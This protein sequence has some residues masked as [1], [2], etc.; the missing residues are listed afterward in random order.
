MDGEK[1]ELSRINWQSCFDFVHVFRAFKIAL[2]PSMLFVTL[3]G[4]ACCY[5][6][7]VVMDAFVRSGY[8]DDVA[9]GEIAWID[10]FVVELGGPHVRS[11]AEFGQPFG[12]VR[13]ELVVRFH[14]LIE[15][16]SQ[17]RNPL[18]GFD[19]PKAEGGALAHVYGILATGLWLFCHHPAY[20]I[21]FS[22]ICLAV[23]SA[24]GG[25]ISRMAALKATRDE[26]ITIR[27][28]FEFATGKYVNFLTAPLLPLI[29]VCVMGAFLAIGALIAMIPYLGD[30][31]GGLLFIAALLGGLLMGLVAVGG[32]GGSFLL[33]PTIAVES[34]DSFD[35]TSRAFSYFYQKPW[36]TS[37][38]VAV[39][40]IYGTLC[41]LFLRVVVWAWLLL[42]HVGLSAGSFGTGDRTVDMVGSI[43]ARPGFYSLVD[44]SFQ[45]L[46]HWEAFTAFF[47]QIC[48]YV[49]V[50]LLASFVI[51][52][53]FSAST[54]VY[55][56]LRS[57]ADAT[58]M[59]EVTVEEEEDEEP[60]ASP[61]PPDESSGPESDPKAT[62]Q[63]SAESAG[64]EVDA[65]SSEPDQPSSGTSDSQDQEERKEEDSKDESD[66]TS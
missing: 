1:Q 17:L 12:M 51:C 6:S 4:V 46:R 19:D 36:R 21:I 40:A 3:I 11:M 24:V 16:I 56:L 33:F 5:A 65:S 35:A 26:Q 20:A 54:I 58:D 29:L 59:D 39:A 32:L 61:T 47:I 8:S 25:A 48:L 44:V 49:V 60:F 15:S 66:S 27:E 34:S 7:G 50:A 9:V 2:N 45:G 31:I 42:T 37:L 10:T 13:N 18:S 14:G 55:L 23:W 30:L 22:A 52:Y 64:A 57:H 53:Y 62:E 28:A 41:Y 43:W 63:P 38:Y